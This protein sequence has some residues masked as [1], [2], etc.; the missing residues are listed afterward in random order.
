VRLIFCPVL[1]I[2]I[3]NSSEFW[4]EI[5]FTFLSHPTKRMGC[6]RSPRLLFF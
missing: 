1:R 6:N 3:T 2:S 4:L 5:V